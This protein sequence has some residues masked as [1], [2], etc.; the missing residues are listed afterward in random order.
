MKRLA[1]AAFVG[2]AAALGVVLFFGGLRE[3]GL[4]VFLASSDCHG[5]CDWATWPGPTCPLI[6]IGIGGALIGLSLALLFGGEEFRAGESAD[7]PQ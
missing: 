5:M 2:A 1:K 3:L 6:A 4:G 7:H